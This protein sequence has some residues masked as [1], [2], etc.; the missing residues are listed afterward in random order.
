[1][2]HFKCFI[3]KKKRLHFLNRKRRIV[4]KKK[5]TTSPSL[6][7]EPQELQELEEGNGAESEEGVE[8]EESEE[9]KEEIEGEGL[10]LN[11][12]SEE[13]GKKEEEEQVNQLPWEKLP[14]L[15]E[16]REN[17]FKKAQKELRLKTPINNQKGLSRKL[18][19]ICWKDSPFSLLSSSPLVLPQ[20]ENSKKEL[21]EE[22]EKK[23]GK[24][25]LKHLTVVSSL[26]TSLS[27]TNIEDDL[28]RELAFYNQAKEAVEHSWKSLKKLGVKMERPE[29]YFAEMLK[30]D[31]HMSNVRGRLIREKRE[32]EAKEQRRHQRMIKK[33]GKQ[34]QLQKQQEKQQQ[35]KKTLSLLDTW[36]KKS[37]LEKEKLSLDDLLASD[38]P[39]SSN[40][41]SRNKRK[42]I[43]AS[44]SSSSTESEK[45]RN[46]KK[47]R[48][49]R[50]KQKKAIQKL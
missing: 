48:K 44:L 16:E 19:Q 17:L 40:P 38:T 45:K 28:Q 37:K 14:T 39:S 2:I 11:E 12:E 23:E 13:E 9:E 6:E 21:G 50:T 22:K 7:D 31:Y 41:N 18:S 34:T 42:Q 1:L 10:E 3:T 15:E 5:K 27:I 4:R 24:L 8:R 47:K 32:L 49:E 36:K 46:E 26:P 35:K 29:D 20:K 30:S 25:W 43:E 33:I